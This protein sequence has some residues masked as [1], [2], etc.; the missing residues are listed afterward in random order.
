MQEDLFQKSGQ[1]LLPFQGEVRY[2]PDFI[3][4]GNHYTC[5][6]SDSTS[7]ASLLNDLNPIAVCHFAASINVSESIA[8]PQQYYTNNVIGT[9][10]LLTAMQAA[11]IKYLIFSSLVSLENPEI[12]LDIDVE[13]LS[14]TKIIESFNLK[15]SKLK[16]SREYTQA[17]V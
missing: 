7:L 8:N 5:C 3:Q 11:S 13:L 9:L 17:F 12:I 14:S 6:L 4:W 15:V 16:F 10:N 1:N 2:Y